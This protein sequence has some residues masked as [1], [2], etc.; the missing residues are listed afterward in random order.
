M[1]KLGTAVLALLILGFPFYWGAWGHPGYIMPMVWG[2]LV[3]LIA[4]A[5]RLSHIDGTA[6]YAFGLTLVMS[7]A[8]CTSVFMLGRFL[9]R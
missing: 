6:V 7:L 1:T 9:G 5:R 4:N 8:L 2:A 3:A